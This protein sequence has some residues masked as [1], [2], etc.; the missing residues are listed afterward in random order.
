M[1]E[2]PG[3]NIGQG[4]VAFV[5]HPSAF[6]QAM[7]IS[8]AADASIQQRR[9]AQGATDPAGHPAKRPPQASHGLLPHARGLP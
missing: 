9:H 3:S 6:K 8:S 2:V 7:T 4:F 5:C 1:S